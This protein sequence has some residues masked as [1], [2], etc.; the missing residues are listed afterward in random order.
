MVNNP[1]AVALH[2]VKNL[3][4]DEDISC[5]VSCGTGKYNYVQTLDPTSVPAASSWKRIFEK[6]LDSATDTE[7][8][9]DYL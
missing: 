2:E 6:I 4:P 1:T 3:W 7:G 5:V 8:F 9:L